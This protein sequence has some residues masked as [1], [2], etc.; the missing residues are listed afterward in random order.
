MAQFLRQ[1]TAVTILMGQF[2]DSTDGATA[3]TALSIAQADVRLSKNGADPAQ[4]DDSGTAVHKENGYYA[5]TLDA[6]DTGALGRLRVMI[7]KATALG[8][9]DDFVV[10]PGPVFD[11]LVSGTA[12]L[13]ANVLQ[14]NGHAVEEAI[15]GEP[16]V[17]LDATQTAYAPAKAGDEMD[18]VNSPN[19]VGIGVIVQAIWGTRPWQ[20]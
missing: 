17:T 12:G 3:K 1:S 8:V 6:T 11:A 5:V 10:F 4:K 16:V 19:S 15:N 14:W 2:V 9:K 7:S 18:I 13:A 20:A